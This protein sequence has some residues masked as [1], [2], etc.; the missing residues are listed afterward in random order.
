MN[1]AVDCWRQ[2]TGQGKGELA[3]QS[4][5]WNVY[6]ERDG[7]LRTQT[8]DKYLS[9]ETLPQRPRWRQVAATAEFVLA[10]C[11]QRHACHRELQNALARLKQL[12]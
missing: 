8:L 9:E 10:A 3:T 6:M 4:G 12:G 7:Y 11:A 1:T 2:T 5:L